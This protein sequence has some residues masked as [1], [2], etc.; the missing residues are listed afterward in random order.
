MGLVHYVAVLLGFIFIFTGFLKL[1]PVDLGPGFTQAEM[2]A[3]FRKYVSVLPITHI[4]GVTITTTLYRSAVGL[5]ETILGSM[6]AF[7]RT[8]WRVFGAFYLLVIMIGAVAT[9][10]KVGDPMAMASPPLI[11]AIFLLFIL[12]NRRGLST[13][14]SSSKTKVD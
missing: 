14:Y 12:V 1:M 5:A 7:G 2:K 10:V 9:H 4:F 3:M 11:L 8:F 13:N 6:L